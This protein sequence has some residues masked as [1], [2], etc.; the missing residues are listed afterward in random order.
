MSTLYTVIALPSL[1][2]AVLAVIAL[3]PVCALHSC[4]KTLAVLLDAVGFLAVTSFGVL[5]G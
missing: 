5:D 4:L 2:I 1:M 3:A